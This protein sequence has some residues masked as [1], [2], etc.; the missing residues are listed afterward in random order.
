M[1]ARKQQRVGI[2]LGAILMCAVGVIG[3]SSGASAIIVPENCGDADEAI[4]PQR[5]DPF[6]TVEHPPTGSFT[7]STGQVAPIPFPVY[8]ADTSMVYGLV[9]ASMAARIMEG[10]GHQPVITRGRAIARLLIWELD[11]AVGPYE[12]LAILFD[13]STEEIEVP[14]VNAYSSF[15]PTLDA[16]T[17][18]FMHK[19]IL[20]RWPSI[21]WGREYVGFDKIFGCIDIER[22]GD[23]LSG[24]TR[25]FAFQDT[26][27]RAV[28][29]GHLNEPDMAASTALAPHRLGEAMGLNSP[30]YLPSLYPEAVM[31]G[32]S[33]DVMNGGRTFRY[34][35]VNARLNG[36]VTEFDGELQI[37]DE[38]PIGNE[39]KDLGFEP[40]IVFRDP[41]VMFV[42]DRAADGTPLIP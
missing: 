18:L 28:L 32:V 10:S 42:M 2:T 20:D 12:E 3:A 11:T 33:P 34:N 30:L 35:V 15:V 7:L 39:L 21:H 19:L 8:Q 4:S 13:S 16:R 36:V 23:P 6:F 25:T 17:T 5:N 31:G 22:T 41:N 1:K 38:S 9:D 14:W 24:T 27:G 26:E 37:S 40:T 29:S